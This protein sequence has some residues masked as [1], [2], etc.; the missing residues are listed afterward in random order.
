MKDIRSY[1]GWLL[2]I[3]FFLGFLIL[4]QTTIERRK[5]GGVVYEHVVTYSTQGTNR[6]ITIIKTD[7]GYVEEERGL[8][9]YVVPIGSR[10]TIEVT[11]TKHKE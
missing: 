4:I 9:M 3:I 7:D 11:R 6:Y 2:M 8:R 10:V 1:W 5:V